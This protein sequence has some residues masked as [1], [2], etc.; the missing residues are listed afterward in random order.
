LAR[1]ILEQDAAAAIFIRYF[2]KDQREKAGSTGDN[3][4]AMAVWCCGSIGRMSLWAGWFDNPLQHELV[5]A[6]GFE[7]TTPS[8]PD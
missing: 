5:G 2:D 4:L 7:P 8:P 1:R 6:A 3:K